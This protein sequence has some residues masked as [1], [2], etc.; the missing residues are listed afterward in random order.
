MEDEM[1]HKTP[2]QE[3]SVACQEFM[4]QREKLLQTKRFLTRTEQEFIKQIDR[5][6]SVRSEIHSTSF[7]LHF[8]MSDVYDAHSKVLYEKSAMCFHEMFKVY[9][10][11]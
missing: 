5:M 11:A 6:C 7:L 9:E 1:Y 2:N 8:A 4:A 3:Y 10:Q